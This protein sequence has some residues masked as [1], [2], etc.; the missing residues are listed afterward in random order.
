M[1]E[2][3]DAFN[4]PQYVVKDDKIGYK[5]GHEIFFAYDFRYKTLFAHYYEHFKNS[6]ISEQSLNQKISMK[7]RCGAFSYA[8]LPKRFDVIMGVTGTLRH[9]SQPE[10]AIMKKEYG[11]KVHT[12]MPSLFGETKNKF[13]EQHDVQISTMER[14]NENLKSEILK[15]LNDHASPRCVFVFFED[16][17]KLKN[18]Y[19]CAEFQPFKQQTRIV[20]EKLSFDEIDAEIKRASQ[21]NQITLLT[22]SFG[23]GA[24]FYVKNGLVRN[25]GG[26]HVVQTFISLQLSEEVQ[27]RGRTARQGGEG[28][29]S[30]VLIAEELLQEFGITKEEIEQA[31]QNQKLY[32]M[33]KD[34]RKEK[35][36]VE[37]KHILS[38]LESAKNEHERGVSFLDALFNG[39]M[40]EI[41]EYLST[42][43]THSSLSDANNFA[44]GWASYLPKK[45]RKWLNSVMK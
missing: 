32:E 23:R 12:Y 22:K 1:M 11:L 17:G 24:D 41:K 33:I 36:A 31:Q 38:R 5:V 28:S 29:Y 34:K 15:R 6:A 40:K 39:D 21:S 13:H 16:E 30:M 8:E 2:D 14:F 10:L 9:L 20:T 45:V 37:Y 35:F 27:I 44:G 18:F 4:S 7:I 25:N 43:N 19:E 42:C 26:P 3:I